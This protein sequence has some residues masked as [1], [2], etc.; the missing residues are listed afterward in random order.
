MVGIEFLRFVIE[1][2]GS[3][4]GYKCRWYPKCSNLD[5]VHIMLHY[6]IL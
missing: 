4:N 3:G 6:I 5:S 1:E 2:E